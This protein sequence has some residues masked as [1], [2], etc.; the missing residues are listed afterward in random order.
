MH[1]LIEDPASLDAFVKRVAPQT[2]MPATRLKSAIA[3][4]FGFNHVG[5]L[6]SA[7]RPPIVHPAKL[8][9]SSEGAKAE[10]T[11]QFDVAQDCLSRFDVDSED[12]LCVEHFEQNEDSLCERVDD[13][14]NEPEL[15]QSIRLLQDAGLT[16]TV[17]LL[18]DLAL[19]S[20]SHAYLKD[21][22]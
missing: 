17:Y 19:L 21:L 8:C 7:L 20:K 9:T 10:T 5:G 22:V 16:T 12:E 14:V 15:Q 3:K 2:H 1:I 6:E 11:F 18:R 13:L 4:G